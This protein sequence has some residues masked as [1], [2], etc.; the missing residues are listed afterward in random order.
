MVVS[1]DFKDTLKK[2][3]CEGVGPGDSVGTSAVCACGH[4]AY[5]CMSTS[6]D[7]QNL[8]K[9]SKWGLSSVCLYSVCWAAVVRPLETV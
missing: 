5:V 9:E 2:D 6:G 4:A 7:S 1:T 8:P 3:V